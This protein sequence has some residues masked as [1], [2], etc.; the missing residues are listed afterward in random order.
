MTSPC[1]LRAVWKEAR[2]AL[3]AV[4]DGTTFA[5]IRERHKTLCARQEKVMDYAI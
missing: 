5:D 3:A 4:L 2:D 1:G